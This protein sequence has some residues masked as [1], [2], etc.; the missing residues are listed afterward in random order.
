MSENPIER[1]A[2]EVYR[3]S[4]YASIGLELGVSVA[5]GLFIGRW[6]DGHLNSDP[7]GLLGGLCLGFAAAIRSISRT[8]MALELENN[9]QKS[10]DESTPE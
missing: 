1:K 7:W 8:L 10:G 4:R 3:A 9:A 2:R 6:V 5:I